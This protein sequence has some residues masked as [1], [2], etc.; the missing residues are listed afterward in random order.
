V[1]ILQRKRVVIVFPGQGSIRSLESVDILK[2]SYALEL[3]AKAQN[4]LGTSILEMMRK[5]SAEDLLKTSY[6]QPITFFLGLL[7]FMILKEEK[8]VYVVGA[9]G[10]SL[11]EL[12]ALTASGFFDIPTGFFIVS[13]RARAMEAACRKN[14]GSMLAV[15]GDSPLSLSRLAGRFGVYVANINSPNQVVYA[16]SIEALKAFREE[17]ASL[18]Y[19]AVYL[20]VEGAFHTPLMEQAASELKKAIRNVK[21]SRGAFP[22]VSNVDGIPYEEN[23]VTEKLIRQIYSPVRWTDCV[24]YLD[25][26]NPSIWIEA[27]PGNVLL[28]L[29]PDNIAGKRVGLKDLQS[30]EEI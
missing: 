8:G 11:G 22:V 28:K 3:D 7:S 10:H 5:A 2:S 4:V 9:A 6:S 14:L 21:V 30:Y 24:E 23:D 29:L 17:V 12:T 13:Q 18:G 26:L 1:V 15:I 25:N 16:G 27:Y 19:R 20:K